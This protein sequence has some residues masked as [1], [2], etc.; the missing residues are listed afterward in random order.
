[1][2]NIYRELDRATA[3]LVV[4]TSG[5][6]YPAAGFVQIANQRQIRTLYVGPEEPLNVDAFDEVM[7]STT[8]AALPKLM[9]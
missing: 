7:L 2:D 4:G 6:V 9:E 3:L 8:T 5:Y 1:M